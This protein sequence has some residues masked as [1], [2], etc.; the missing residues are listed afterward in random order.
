MNRVGWGW[1][2][3]DTAREWGIGNEEGETGKKKI[4][5]WERGEGQEYCDVTYR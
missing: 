4:G 2:G 3:G 1:I 5:R